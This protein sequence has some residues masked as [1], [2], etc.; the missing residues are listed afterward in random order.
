MEG[1]LEIGYQKEIW[2]LLGNGN[3][4]EGNEGLGSGTLLAEEDMWLFDRVQ[5]VHYAPD[6]WELIQVKC[7]IWISEAAI[8]SFEQLCSQ[9]NVQLSATFK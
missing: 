8:M 5:H 2:N 6:V 3:V 1:K 4:G 9:W 7:Q